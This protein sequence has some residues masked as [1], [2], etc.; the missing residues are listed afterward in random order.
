MVEKYILGVKISS[1]S[2]GRLLTEIDK[3]IKLGLKFNILAI[4]PEKIM[5]ARREKDGIEILNKGTINIADGVGLK[6]AHSNLQIIKGRELFYKL[7]QNKKYKKF[8]LGGEDNESKKIA[9]KFGGEWFVGPIINDK[10]KPVTKIDVKLYKDAI[11][12]INK[13]KPDI[14]FVAFGGNNIKQER[15][16][17]ENFNKLKAKCIMAVGGSFRYYSGLSKLPPK[18]ISDVGMEW[19]WRLL[20][21]PKRIK[22]IFNATILF[23][24]EILKDKLGF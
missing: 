19:L 13:Y 5:D 23:P 4:N 10:A 1:T 11:D 7:C 8:Y 2:E 17:I 14:L 12:K 3:N 22:R 15:F 21:E 24:I 18:S 9:E 6:L 16:I 20:T